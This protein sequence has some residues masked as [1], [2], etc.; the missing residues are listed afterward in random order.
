M[1]GHG[2]HARFLRF[3]GIQCFG[4]IVEIIRVGTG[5]MDGL[6]HDHCRPLL[7]KFVWNPALPK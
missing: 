5:L 7:P 2:M 6:R 1:Y 3:Q 4:L